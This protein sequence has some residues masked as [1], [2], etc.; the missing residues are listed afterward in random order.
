[1]QTASNGLSPKSF[2]DSHLGK[3]ILGK[4]YCNPASSALHTFSKLD[5]LLLFK[6]P[7]P[8]FKCLNFLLK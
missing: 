5:L 7:L 3:T 2:I 6:D 1:M 4:C 8:G